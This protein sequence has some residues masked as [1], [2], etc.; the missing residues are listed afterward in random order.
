MALLDALG[1][2]EPKPSYDG[3]YDLD[4]TVTTADG[5]TRLQGAINLHDFVAKD[6]RG[7]DSFR[8]ALVRGYQRRLP[9]SFNPYQTRVVAVDQ[10]TFS[11]ESSKTLV[12][13]HEGV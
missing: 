12:G 11:M 2:Q 10:A 3:N 7:G 9:P 13:R 5:V 8:E 4:Q 1:G 6:D